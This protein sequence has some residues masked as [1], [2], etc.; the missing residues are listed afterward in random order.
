MNKRLIILFLVLLFS[1]S[2]AFAQATLFVSPPSGTYQTGEFFSVLVKVNTGGKNI[3]A[4]SGQLNFDNSKL[5]VVSLGYSSSIFSIWTD[6]PNFSN[7]GGTVKFSGGVPN[8]GYTGASG[9]ILR[10]TF[11]AKAQGQAPLAFVTGSVLANDGSG[12]NILDS[13]RG[14]LF[15][16]IAAAGKPVSAPLA[17]KAEPAAKAASREE[18]AP[19]ITD[20][21]KQI[22]EG[23]TLTIKGVGFPNGK[24]LVVF[25]KG[26]GEPIT[27]ETFSGP[28]GRFSITYSR[29]VTAGFYRIW[30]RDISAE[31]VP[32]ANSEAVLTEVIRPLFFRIGNIA[33][34]YAS[35]IVTLLALLLLVSVMLVWSWVRFRKW[36]ER[37]GK[38]ISEAEKALHL[39]FDKLK[40]GLSA[41]VGYLT[42]VRSTREG[43][44][45]GEMTKKELKEEL[46]TIEKDIEKEVEDIKKKK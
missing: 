20:W 6:E 46:E 9:A 43:K 11:K 45:R 23:T 40:D 27:Q 5:E 2:I 37:Q 13:F 21:P 39:G 32:S 31:G 36:H 25:Q 15:Q 19:I 16:I 14:S 42:D 10:L 1:P 35:L 8:P 38:E 34:N 26:E 44:K 3:N 29:G 33:I 4:A 28:D 30:A 12:T 18:S 22:E 17:P 7:V 24:L 41:Y